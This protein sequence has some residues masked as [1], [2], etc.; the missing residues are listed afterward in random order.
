MRIFRVL[1]K[2]ISSFHV[3]FVQLFAYQIH[4]FILNSAE[5]AIGVSQI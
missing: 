5:K 4:S 2:I 1:G 3:K